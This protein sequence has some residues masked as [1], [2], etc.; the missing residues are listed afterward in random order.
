VR[1]ELAQVGVDERHDVTACGCQTGPQRVALPFQ[2][3]QA[4]GHL[5]LVDHPRTGLARDARGL[6]SGSGVDDDDL[7]DQ[8]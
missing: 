8:R 7:V 3:G 5:V 2:P 6:V 1:P 4:P